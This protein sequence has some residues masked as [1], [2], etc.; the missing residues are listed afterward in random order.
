MKLLSSLLVLVISGIVSPVVAAGQQS[1]GMGWGQKAFIMDVPS[2]PAQQ[3][4]IVLV[5]ADTSVAGATPQPDYILKYCKETESTGDSRSAMRAVDPASMLIIYFQQYK[6]AG[7]I[8][9]TEIKNISL[10]ENTKHGEIISGTTNT[11]RIAFGYDPEP[12]YVGKDRAVFMAEYQ[13]VRYKIVVDLRVFL[14]FDEKT[15]VCPPPQLIKVNKPSSSNSGYDLNSISTSFGAL[16]GAAVGQ[17]VGT[18]ITHNLLASDATMTDAGPSILAA[19]PVTAQTKYDAAFSICAS[20]VPVGHNDFSALNGISPLSAA[21]AYFHAHGSD[22]NI[23]QD[24]RLGLPPEPFKEILLE[25]PQHGELRNEN[26]YYP[27]EGYLGPDQM[28]FSV[29]VKG[30]VFKVIYSVYVNRSSEYVAPECGNNYSI[31]E[32]PNNTYNGGKGSLL[33]ILELPISGTLDTEA[34]AKLHAMVSFSMGAGLSGSLL[35]VADLPGAAVGQTVG[36]NITLDSN[37]AGYNWFIDTTPADNSEFLPTSNPN[38]WVAKEGSAAYGK[39]DMLSVLLHEYGHA[40]GIDHS[41]DP[42]DYM[43]TTLTAGVRRMPSAEELALMQQLVGQ[44]KATLT[45][46]T[47]SP[48]LPLQGGGSFP[49]LPLSTSFIGFLGLLH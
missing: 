8:D 25:S 18:S 15:P 6:G 14:L 10:L 1:E 34:F 44:V 41:A 49:T 16:D 36:S 38:E 24:P 12:E 35:N 46:S 9:D 5:Q 22:L 48:T 31:K 17:T 30:K 40:L 43:G 2:V 21:Q 45:E 4:P 13:G 32:L 3:T 23:F 7:F 47:L 19:A 33:N 39:M 20:V 11:G 26:L 27:N 42:H 37:A 29:E 28:T